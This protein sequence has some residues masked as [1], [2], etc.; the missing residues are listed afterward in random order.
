MSRVLLSPLAL[1]RRALALLVL[2]SATWLSA[3]GSDAPEP[4]GS[5]LSERWLRVGQEHSV[6]VQVLE[7]QLPPGLVDL[8]NPRSG[9][10]A[11]DLI[12]FPVHPD[13][14]LVGSYVMRRTNG[15]QVVWLFYDVPGQNLGQVA[16]T[17]AAQLDE[18]PWQVTAQRGNRSYSVV[19]FESTRSGDVIGNTFVEIVSPG[20]TYS[21][22]VLRD[23]AEVTL[24]VARIAPAPPIEAELRGNLEVAQVFPGTARTAGLA[25]G[26]RIVRVGATEVSTRAELQRVLEGMANEVPVVSIIYALQFASPGSTEVPFVMPAGVALPAR[27]PAPDAWRGFVIDEYETIVDTQG[28]Y[29]AASLFS[30]DHPSAVADQIR[31]GLESSGWTILTDE[32]RGLAT[33]IEFGRPDQ[34]LV[35][36]VQIDESV[37]DVNLTQAFVQIQTSAPGGN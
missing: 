18:S 29:F 19:R 37:V 26:D 10:D 12:A 20:D 23:D 36:I 22:T 7:R 2:L 15:E 31:R 3:C 13:G 17:V 32:A 11:S 6:N 21:L 25:A 1:R 24:D 27:F 30:K 34:R 8:L 16:T 5:A 33:Q 28:S 4:S 35:G 14:E 9:A